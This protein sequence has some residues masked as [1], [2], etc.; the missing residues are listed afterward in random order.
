MDERF[1]FGRAASLQED[2]LFSDALSAWAMASLLNTE[3]PY[4]H[5]HAAECYLSLQNRKDALKALHEA[6]LRSEQ[7]PLLREKISVLKEQWKKIA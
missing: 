2:A 5:F 6:E 7:I 1:W 3:D 4:P